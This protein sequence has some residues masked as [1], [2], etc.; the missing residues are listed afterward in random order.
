MT[1]IKQNEVKR[2]RDP[3][4]GP[5]I[6]PDKQYHSNNQA[7]PQ[8]Q[9]IDRITKIKQ[10]QNKVPSS[11]HPSSQTSATTSKTMKSQTSHESMKVEK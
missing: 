8:Q 2:R 1:K 6:T 3:V 11:S 7:N 5:R 10:N 4:L 9:N